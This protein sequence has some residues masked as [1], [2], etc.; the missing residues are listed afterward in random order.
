VRNQ[1][2]EELNTAV[3]TY[4]RQGGIVKQLPMTEAA[5]KC[6]TPDKN[7]QREERKRRR[8]FRAQQTN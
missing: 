2:R 6:L 4:L 7:K 3:G 1:K 8:E 5:I